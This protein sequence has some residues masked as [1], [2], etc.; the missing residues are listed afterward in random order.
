M[1]KIPIVIACLLFFTGVAYADDVG[2]KWD[3]VAGAGG[4]KIYIST[5]GGNTWDY[6]TGIDV[7]NVTNYVYTNVPDTGMILFR[8][9][10]YNGHGEK[11]RYKAGVFYCGDCSPP[12]EPTGIGIE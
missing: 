2:L 12:N 6:N 10:A 8:A 11:I 9:S 4:Y 3:A 5:D 1:K 7:G